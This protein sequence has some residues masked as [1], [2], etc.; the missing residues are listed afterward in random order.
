MA[1]TA[2]ATQFRVTNIQTHVAH[3]QIN[4]PSKLNA[5]E[6]SMWQELRCI[7]EALSRN[8]QTRV[9]LFSGSGSAFTAGLDIAAAARQS[10]FQSP[11]KGETIDVARRS[12]ELRRYIEDF[13]EC[14]NSIERCEKRKQPFSSSQAISLICLV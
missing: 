8:P 11:A 2:R 6:P 14:V 3:V 4:R 1:E 7:F 10:F 5:F 13:Q 9:V 12:I